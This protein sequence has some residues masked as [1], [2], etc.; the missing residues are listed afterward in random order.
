MAKVTRIYKPNTRKQ[1]ES[2]T[3]LV[4]SQKKQL[5]EIFE[6]MKPAVLPDTV[7][8]DGTNLEDL[9]I[10]FQVQQNKKY[11]LK[12]ETYYSNA[13]LDG[14]IELAVVP[15]ANISNFKVLGFSFNSGGTTS[16][17]DEENNYDGTYQGIAWVPSTEAS[18][19]QGYGT[20]YFTMIEP[21][22][23][24]LSFRAGIGDTA[25]LAGS[26]FT[27]SEIELND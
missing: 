15:V 6:S 25:M 17:A 14:T 8:S 7:T 10:Y 23:L 27:L 21:A 20:M 2:L 3:Q 18:V 5:I 26:N 11:M 9:G 1:V 4:G 13:T 19:A 22:I 16:A 24:S 12:V